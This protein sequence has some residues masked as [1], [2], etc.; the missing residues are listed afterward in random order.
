MP[1]AAVAALPESFVV[2]EPEGAVP[3]VVQLRDHDGT[4][5]R[6]PEIVLVKRRLRAAGAIQKKVIPIQLAVAQEVEDAAMQ[7]IVPDLMVVL[8]TAALR[9][10]SAPKVERWILNSWIASTLGRTP[11]LPKRALR[12]SI[13]FSRK[14]LLDSRPPAIDRVVSLRPVHESRE[15]SRFRLESLPPSAA[16]VE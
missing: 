6:S 8:I 11:A 10:N 16:R 5:H 13:P 9:P 3:A 4:S 12:V 2:E 15:S 7:L 14:L 1:V